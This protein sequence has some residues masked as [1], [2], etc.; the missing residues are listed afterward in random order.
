MFT[1]QEV[2]HLTLRIHIMLVVFVKSEHLFRSPYVFMNYFD[3]VSIAS[4][5]KGSSHSQAFHKYD[6]QIHFSQNLDFCIL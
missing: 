5:K 4:F 3:S 1:V 2:G 6:L